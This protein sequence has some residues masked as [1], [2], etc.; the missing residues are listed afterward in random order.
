MKIAVFDSNWDYTVE[1]PYNEPLGGTQS[2]IAYFCEEM[3]KSHQVYLF[4]KVKYVLNINNVTHV[5]AT[6]YKEYFN[7]HKLE[8][9]II[10]YEY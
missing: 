6:S 9:D 8:C 1:T 5:P 3:A 2:A 10:I 7:I 4:N